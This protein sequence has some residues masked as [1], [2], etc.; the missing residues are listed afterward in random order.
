MT[1]DTVTLEIAA[2][3][4]WHVHLRDDE[5]L[6]AVTPY[7]ANVFRHAVVMPNIN[8]PVTS[9]Q[10]AAAYRARVLAAAGPDARHDFTPMMVLYLNDQIVVDDLLAGAADGVVF[11]AKYYPAGATTNSAAGG[12]DLLAFRPVLEAMAGAGIPLL[13]HAESTDPSLDIFDREADFIENQLLPVVEHIP[14]LRGTVE[15]ISTSLLL[16]RTCLLYTSD[17]ADE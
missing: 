17:A 9:T 14:E 4:D 12:N 16:W 2:P 1:D 3:D 15:H 6:S 5:M 7:T 10:A 13:V 11:G 8:P